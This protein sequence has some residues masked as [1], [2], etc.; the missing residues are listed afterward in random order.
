VR[1]PQQ[2]EAVVTRGVG[3]T[4]PD[5][6]SSDTAEGTAAL[7]AAFKESWVIW[8]TTCWHSGFRNIFFWPPQAETAE[9]LRE[10]LDKMMAEALPKLRAIVKEAEAAAERLYVTEEQRA[11]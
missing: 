8:Y 2:T 5:F 1:E 4:F 9:E 6:G 7:K 10:Q 11:S 3:V